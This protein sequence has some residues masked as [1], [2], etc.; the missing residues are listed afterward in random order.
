MKTANASV[1][2]LAPVIAYLESL[3]ANDTF[4]FVSAPLCKPIT[5]ELA[6]FKAMYASCQAIINGDE[7]DTPLIE[8][9][10]LGTRIAA[11]KKT[12]AVA[13]SLM[14]SIAKHGGIRR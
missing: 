13:N 4:E 12:A 11:V 14:G 6:N 1:A 3:V 9:K 8:V 10:E 5:D 7:H 2:K